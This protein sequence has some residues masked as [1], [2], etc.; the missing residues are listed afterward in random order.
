VLAMTALIAAFRP[1][2]RAANT[3]PTIAL[4]AQ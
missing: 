4:R 2:H 3:N 1:A